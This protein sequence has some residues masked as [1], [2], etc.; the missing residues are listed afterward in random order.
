[1][2]WLVAVGCGGGWFAGISL[3]LYMALAGATNPP[4]QW[5][6]PRIV[7]G[8]WHALTRGQYEKANPTN[9]FE[10]PLRFLTQLQMVAEGITGEFSWILP[11]LAIIPFLFLLRMQKRERAWIL[12]LSAMY[13]CMAFLL[14]ILLNPSPD[15]ASRDLTRVFFTAS[16]VYIAMLIGY[17]LTL[18]AA[19]G[20][21]RHTI[22]RHWLPVAA[23]ILVV[24]ALDTLFSVIFKMHGLGVAS[25]GIRSVVYAIVCLV[26][27]GMLLRRYE[28]GKTGFLVGAGTLGAIGLI[29]GAK[30]VMAMVTFNVSVGACIGVLT[31]GVGYTLSHGDATLQI[32]G[33]LLI[34][35][36]TGV[37]VFLLWRKLEGRRAT[38]LLAALAVIPAYSALSHWFDN[39]QRGHLF[40]YWFGHDMFTPPF[41]APDGELS[42]ER[43]LR[44]ELMQTSEQKDLIYPEMTRDA[45]LFGGTDPGRFCPTYMIFC[46]SFIP[47]RCKPLDPEFDRRDVYIITQNALADGTYLHYI[48]AHYNKSEQRKY[49]TPFFQEFLRSKAEREQNYATNALARLAF[50]I[51][52][53]P[54]LAVGERIEAD[55]REKGVYPPEEIYIPTP[56]DSS[57]SFEEYL[58]DAQVRLQQGRLKPGEDVRVVNN[59]VQVSGQVAVMAINGLLTKVIFDNNPDNEFFVEESFPLDW[60]YPHLTPFGVIMKINREPLPSLSEKVLARDHHF[61]RKFSERSI[62]DWI[63]YDTPVEEIAAF[64]ERTYLRHDFD[65]FK[66]DRK[67][68]RD[69]S[70]QKAFSKLRSSI[71]GVYA[72]R[73]G[74][75]AK[76]TGYGPKTEAE[77]Q[78]L[79]KEAD[80]TFRQAF[81]FCPYSPEAVFRY[82]NLL[83]MQGRYDDAGIVA[84]TCLKLDPYNGQ[85]ADLVRRLGEIESQQTQMRQANTGLTQLQQQWNASPTNLQLGLNLAA[86]LLQLRQTNAAISALDRV[87]ASTN[88]D[89]GVVLAC[90]QAFLQMNNLPKLEAALQRLTTV[91]P[92][93]PE[94]WYDLAAIKATLGKQE[95]AVKA[96]KQSVQLSDVRLVTTPTAKNLRNEVVKDARMASVRS[97]PEFQN[98]I[99]VPK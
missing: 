51:L 88:L 9:I 4:M 64:A 32:Y 91:T 27:A 79:I 70:A 38:L 86:N 74:P 25:E 2:E 71:G 44:E 85:V 81:A 22:I 41:T 16:H 42:Y 31:S 97:H 58:Q 96:L 77:R 75:E 87:L 10:D 45:I 46:E 60:M 43:A 55:R 57:K 40:G 94:A 68:V 15:R 98:I 7:D 72:W 3:Y 52:D 8:F 69:T 35:L 67:F 90:A 14:V 93:S 65:G 26:T 18:I 78:R 59:R 83:M 62:G 13:V 33:G 66:G 82:V 99:A 28:D 56:R 36:L 1:M 76:A 24:T 20:I 50:K 6:Y 34:V 23:P 53:R 21:T 12:G 17:G 61:W 29:A 63:T 48:R 39:E 49:D 19:L 47:P 84:E 37:T 73:L 89:S 30:G 11:L 80:F 5:G 54:L 92:E 95:E